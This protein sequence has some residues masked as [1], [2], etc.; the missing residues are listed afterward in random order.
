MA[1]LFFFFNLRNNLLTLPIITTLLQNSFI[2]SP[3]LLSLILPLLPQSPLLGAVGKESSCSAGDPCL[4]PGL[5]IFPGEQ[6]DKPPQ[7]SCLE[8]PMEREAW[9]ATVHGVASMRHNSAAK[10]PPLPAQ[11]NSSELLEAMSLQSLFCPK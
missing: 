3:Y 10:P 4:I 1:H 9:Q 5:G 7:Y 2:L 11:G 6:N 8:N